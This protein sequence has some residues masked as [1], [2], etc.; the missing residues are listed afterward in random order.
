M[1]CCHQTSV[2]RKVSLRKQSK[3]KTNNTRKRRKRGWSQVKQAERVDQIETVPS[4]LHPIIPGG[5]ACVAET[6][7]FRCS[8]GPF[9]LA[10]A[11]RKRETGSRGR[12]GAACEQK[13]SR[14]KQWRVDEH[15]TKR[16]LGLCPSCARRRIILCAFGARVFCLDLAL[17]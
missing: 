4:V 2:C 11:L 17:H 7:F 6:P 10:S 8:P 12:M 9:P 15:V 13:L 1:T 3:T 14:V 16:V 5:V